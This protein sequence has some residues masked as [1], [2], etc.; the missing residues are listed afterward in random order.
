MLGR[1]VA[2]SLV[3]VTC[4]ATSSARAD[5]GDH[6]VINVIN[7]HVYV[8]LGTRD[9]AA[10]GDRIEIVGDNG[11]A[12]GVLELDLCGEVIC[13]ARLPKGLAGTIAR[14]MQARITKQ[15]GAAT[16]Q[17]KALPQPAPV[18]PIRTP[19]PQTKAT[20]GEEPIVGPDTL[21]YRE[22]IPRGYE[23]RRKNYGGL[24]ALGWVGFSVSY[25]VTALVGLGGNDDKTIL[26]LP[27]LGPLI[28]LASAND[29]YGKPEPAPYVFSALLQG[30][31]VL[32]LIAGY[33]GEK[34]LV[35]IGSNASVS[36]APAVTPA[37]SYLGIVG[38]F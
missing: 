19:E 23:M 13:R 34:T 26:L 30:A 9:G 15:A 12:V 31:S 3:I 8:S 1:Q 11:V 21:P 33:S 35:R 17:P 16:P 38:R 29:Y 5:D 4:V 25:G 27:V 18:V 2:S 36:I 37:G 32:S 6:P 22:P 14:G 28:Y 10:E 24:V 20:S 7:G